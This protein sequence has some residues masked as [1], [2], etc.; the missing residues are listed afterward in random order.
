MQI[1]T[2]PRMRTHPNKA[3]SALT[4]DT[5]PVWDRLHD[6]DP[7]WCVETRQE[8][9]GVAAA[10]DRLTEKKADKAMYLEGG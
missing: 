3:E 6:T 2:T 1:D 8:N 10:C 9:G 5:K 7:G 4:Q